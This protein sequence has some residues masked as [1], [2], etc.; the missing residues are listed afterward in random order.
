KVSVEIFVKASIAKTCL[1]DIKTS[2]IVF[3]D[4]Y[5]FV[6]LDI[7]CIMALASLRIATNRWAVNSI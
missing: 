3:S 1:T 4:F 2:H 7:W 6:L 5:A